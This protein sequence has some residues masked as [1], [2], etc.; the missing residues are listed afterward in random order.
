MQATVL[1][2]VLQVL[3]FASTASA[4]EGHFVYEGE[5]KFYHAL[6]H[7]VVPTRDPDVNSLVE[8]LQS[9]SYFCQRRFQ[10]WL[11][12][13]SMD[14]VEVA[15]LQEVAIS[16]S[17][18]IFSPKLGEQIVVDSEWVE[19]RDVQ[20]KVQLDDQVYSHAL[21]TRIKPRDLTKISIPDAQGGHDFIVRSPNRLGELYSY[22][23]KQSAHRWTEVTVE[24]VFKREAGL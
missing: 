24:V 9:Q 23:I 8:D 4:V 17:Q 10:V 12:Q 22:R 16:Q 1:G 13:K 21:Y 19:Q 5:Q 20:Q 14:P 7:V 11:C 3:F 18:V 6:S 15:P 2:V